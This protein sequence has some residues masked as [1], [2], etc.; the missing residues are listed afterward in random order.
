MT[1]G[2][3][4]CGRIEGHW[5]PCATYPA[6]ARKLDASDEHADCREREAEQIRQSTERVGSIDHVLAG[7]ICSCDCEIKD[8][9]CRTHGTDREWKD[10]QFSRGKSID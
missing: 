10:K 1:C 8:P 4:G 2:K 3:F 7:F 9:K 6:D 5:G